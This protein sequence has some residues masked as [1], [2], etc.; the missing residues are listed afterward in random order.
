MEWQIWSLMGIQ[1]GWDAMHHVHLKTLFLEYLVDRPVFWESEKKLD[2]LEETHTDSNQIS[3]SNPRPWSHQA[4]MRPTPPP[5]YVHLTD[6]YTKQ[7]GSCDSI[8][9]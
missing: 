4:V 1:P 9:F 3:G 7:P 2:Y 6:K 8:T 5:E